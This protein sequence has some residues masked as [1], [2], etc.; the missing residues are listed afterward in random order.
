MDL[1]QIE[2]M[3]LVTQAMLPG[4]VAVG[5]NGWSHGSL[6][7]S[8]AGATPEQSSVRLQAA[9]AAVAALVRDLSIFYRYS[10]DIYGYLLDIFSVVLPLS[11]HCARA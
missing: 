6:G 9:D 10:L 5:G 1:S 3:P 7:F 4:H 8:H 11:C 2:S